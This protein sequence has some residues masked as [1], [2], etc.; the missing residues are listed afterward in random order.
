M[1]KIVTIKRGERL[2]E[3]ETATGKIKYLRWVKNHPRNNRRKRGIKNENRN[4]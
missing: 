4:R 3:V 2:V 1:Y